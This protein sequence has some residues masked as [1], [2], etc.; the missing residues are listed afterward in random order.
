MPVAIAA[1]WI[2]TV[3]GHSRRQILALTDKLKSAVHL[4]LRE[5]TQS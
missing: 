1:P 5:M 4:V 2:F 3:V